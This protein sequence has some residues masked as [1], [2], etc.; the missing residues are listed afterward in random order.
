MKHAGPTGY[1]WYDGLMAPRRC[2]RDRRSVEDPQSSRTVSEDPG[3]TVGAVGD[4]AGQLKSIH[5]PSPPYR[6]LR[7][8]T[9]LQ[10]TFVSELVGMKLRLKRGCSWKG[11]SFQVPG[12]PVVVPRFLGGQRR[13]WS[14]PQFISLTKEGRDTAPGN[15]S[16]TGKTGSVALLSVR[17]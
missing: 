1:D 7:H 9:Q 14:E 17:P 2:L 5:V 4:P 16:T 10:D 11:S 3:W 12:H 6:D 13:M 8:L 15:D